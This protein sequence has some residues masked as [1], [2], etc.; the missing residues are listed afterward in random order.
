MSRRRRTKEKFLA[1]RPA[2]PVLNSSRA[3]ASPAID[4]SALADYVA[5]FSAKTIVLLGDFVADE[6]QFGDISRVSREAPVL[7]LRHNHTH[8]VPGGG[9]NAANN[10]AALGARVFPVTAVG[11]DA[12]GGKLREY[13]Q[14]MGMDVSGVF[15]AKK[16]T[17]PTKTRFLAGWAHT[18]GQQV[19]RVDREPS[20]PLPENVR[21]KL[22]SALAGKLKKAD[23]LAVSDYGF[24]VATPALAR[25]ARVQGTVR[26]HAVI[27]KDGSIQQLEV[28]SGP[29]L[30]IQA[31][32]D[33]VLQ[34]R[35]K[36]TL[37]SDEPVE[38]E[39]FIDVIFTLGG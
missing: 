15:V 26:M 31:A 35:Y 36:P 22:Q 5:Q 2:G 12:A 27:A 11:D 8:L 4:L 32:R 28:V 38:V 20:A 10:F 16:W 3:P 7:I 14:S 13:F 30:L 9:A 6:F 19:L 17:T 23:A 1:V 29:P 25:Q 24:G 37:L 21:A 34:W 39:T 33:A 18:V